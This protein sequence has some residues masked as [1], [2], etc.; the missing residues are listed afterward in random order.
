MPFP[1]PPKNPEN[2]FVVNKAVSGLEFTV[3][4]TGT[5]VW[6]LLAGEYYEKS[7]TSGNLWKV[8]IYNLST[9]TFIGNVLKIGG[10]V[11]GVITG[12]VGSDYQGVAVSG[13]AVSSF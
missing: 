3:A 1:F 10:C 5:P 6:T 7:N 4:L 13:V 8:I 12:V 9:D 2:V 11:V